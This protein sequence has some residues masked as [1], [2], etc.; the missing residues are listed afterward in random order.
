M[1]R[2][3]EEF[4]VFPL[5]DMKTA[6]EATCQPPE[7]LEKK[8]DEKEAE[9]DEDEEEADEEIRVTNEIQVAVPGRT[10]TPAATS[11]PAAATTSPGTAPATTQPEAISDEEGDD[12]EELRVIQLDGKVVEMLKIE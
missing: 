3:A 4:T 6:A 9:K 1:K 11:T 8:E 10:A 7:D 5:H 12:V 2:E